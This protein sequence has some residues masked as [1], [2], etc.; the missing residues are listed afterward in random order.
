M[1]VTDPADI[2]DD[3]I[4]ARVNYKGSGSPTMYIGNTWLTSF[5]LLKDTTGRRIYRNVSELASELTRTAS[6]LAAPG[7]SASTTICPMCARF[8]SR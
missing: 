5:L 8:A 4:A 1:T 3:I 2:I 7:R 6:V